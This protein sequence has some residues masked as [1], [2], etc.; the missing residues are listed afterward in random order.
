MIK[1]CQFVTVLA[2]VV[3]FN[4]LALA[5]DKCDAFESLDFT[6][7]YWHTS[8]SQSDKNEYCQCELTELKKIAPY[9]TIEKCV[10]LIDSMEGEPAQEMHV[11]TALVLALSLASKSSK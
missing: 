6:V 10:S 4:S 1:L 9:A 11:R 3:F 2:V 8:V 7:R 5:Q